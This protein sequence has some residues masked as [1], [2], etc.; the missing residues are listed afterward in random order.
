MASSQG[1]G[2]RRS[3]QDKE[4]AAVLKRQGIERRTGKC[5]ICYGVVGNDTLGGTAVLNHYLQHARGYGDDRK[6]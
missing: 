4:K 3:M 1:A 6:K 5:C 2:A